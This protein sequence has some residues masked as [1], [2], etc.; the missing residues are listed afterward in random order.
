MAIRRTRRLG[1]GDYVST[2][3]E[4]SQ[5]VFIA[6]IALI[7]ATRKP[8]PEFLQTL[9]DEVFPEYCRLVAGHGEFREFTF[10]WQMFRSLPP[11]TDYEQVTKALIGWARRFNAEEDWVIEQAWRAF[12]AWDKFPESRDSLEWWQD[13]GWRN[14]FRSEPF[15][16]KWEPWLPQLRP[17]ITYRAAMQKAFEK[18]VGEFECKT[19]AGALAQGLT[20]APRTHSADNFEWFVLYQFAG[21]S[22]SRIEAK[23][24][25]S[26]GNPDASTILKGVKTAQKLIGWKLLRK[27][28]QTRETR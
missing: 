27:D 2:D 8:L 19:R 6:R 23:L 1:L 10:T 22:S 25:R 21:W 26:D 3:P 14:I 15:Q 13:H 20:S 16:F 17:W 28:S 18:A 7:E 12:K 4:D 24:A 9:F 11:R 5:S